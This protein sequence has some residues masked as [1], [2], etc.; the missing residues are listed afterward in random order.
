MGV[1]P[2]ESNRFED[3]TSLVRLAQQTPQAFEQIYLRYRTP[4]LAFCYRRLGNRDEAEDAASTVF[5]A[6]LR[7]LASFGERG[8]SFRAWLFTI[9]RH[10]LAMRA[11]QRRR[12]PELAIDEATDA[13]DPARSPEELALLADD[14]LRLQAMLDLLSRNERSVLELRFADLTTEEIAE[15]LALTAGNVRTIQSRAVA[16]LRIAYKQIETILE[17]NADV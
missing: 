3:D 1:L 6:A 10:E 13:V 14:Q 16:R 12:H 17:R 5:V 9:A 4:V 15:A 7:G 2:G 8:D 11:R